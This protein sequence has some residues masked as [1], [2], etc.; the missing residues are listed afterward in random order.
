MWN[1]FICNRNRAQI[2]ELK[3]V[4]VAYNDQIEMRSTLEESLQAIFNSSGFSGY[5]PV[6][7]K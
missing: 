1:L 7:S 4:I 3:R 2:P 6:F 5:I